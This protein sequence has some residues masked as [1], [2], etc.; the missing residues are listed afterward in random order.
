MLK[1]RLS[2][3]VSSIVLILIL[4]TCGAPQ[5]EYT[6]SNFL[7][8]APCNITFFYI[9]DDAAQEIIDVIDLELTRLDSLLNRFSDISL[10]SKLNRNARVEAPSDIIHLVS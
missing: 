7:F 10:V 6:Y 8:G 5:K 4:V 2:F 9:G 1:H 3:L